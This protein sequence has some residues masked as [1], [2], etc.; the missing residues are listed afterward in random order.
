MKLLLACCNE[1]NVPI[2]ELPIE[3]PFTQ[4]SKD[5]ICMIIKLLL[6]EHRIVYV[7]RAMAE[8]RKKMADYKFGLARFVYARP[9]MLINMS[10]NTY[11]VFLDRNEITDENK[12]SILSNQ[13]PNLPSPLEENLRDS[14]HALARVLT[15]PDGT[16]NKFFV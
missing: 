15:M 4:L 2:M 13:I 14:I 10:N 8:A 12:Q 11:I 16:L 6:L 3:I 5:R 7:C 1:C 9:E